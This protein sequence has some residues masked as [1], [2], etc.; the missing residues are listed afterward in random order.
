M[1]QALL[2]IPL[3]IP[4][5]TWQSP[6]RRGVESCREGDS[7]WRNCGAS[8][9]ARCADSNFRRHTQLSCA[10]AKVSCGRPRH[11]SGRFDGV[12]DICLALH[13]LVDEGREPDLLTAKVR[14]SRNQEI[15]NAPL[16]LR[17]E[18]IPRKFCLR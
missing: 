2:V 4:G 14:Y 6:R 12:Q 11:G 17:A 18:S 8:L 1:C 10:E 7:P 16:T 3:L 15:H 13:D 5:T 9:P